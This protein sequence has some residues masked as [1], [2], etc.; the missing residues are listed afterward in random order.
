MKKIL[1]EKDNKKSP[2]KK[3]PVRQAGQSLD[4]E[5][6]R[7]FDEKIGYHVVVIVFFL[8]LT[9]IEWYQWFFKV[10]VNPVVFSIMAVI[11]VAFSIKKI[12]IYR[13]DIKKLQMARDGERIVGESLELLREKGYLVFHD[14]IGGDFNIDH[15]I[16]GQ[17]GVFTIET[18][19]ISK[20]AKGPSEIQH[21]GERIIV[22]R[23]RPDRDPIVQARAQAN[24]LRDLF[25][26]FTGKNVSIQ[27]V[28]LYPGWFVSPQPKGAEVWVLNEKAL[29]AFLGKEPS[30]L[31]PEDVHALAAHLAHYVRNA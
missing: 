4:E 3:K 5:I 23:F 14:I 19:T 26:D 2:L 22:D 17:N 28:I 21:D 10:S 8:V 9:L 13:K 7:I 25:K 24:W 29:P 27:P 31:S 6:N 1:Q 20:P 30:I 11:I 18:K 16:V 12:L 15:V